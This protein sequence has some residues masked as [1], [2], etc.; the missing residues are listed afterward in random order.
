MRTT[1]RTASES[2]ISEIILRTLD[3]RIVEPPF[4]DEGGQASFAAEIFSAPRPPRYGFLYED[5]HFDGLGETIDGAFG[6]GVRMD[7]LEEDLCSSDLDN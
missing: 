5:G 7:P 6:E 3:D 4:F 1:T 2:Y